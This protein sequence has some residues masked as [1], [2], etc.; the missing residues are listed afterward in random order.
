MMTQILYNLA[1]KP[2]ISANVK[3]RDVNAS[4]WY[5]TAVAWAAAKGLI[6]GCNEGWLIP[7]GTATRAE[8][9]A[10]LMRYCS[11]IGMSTNKS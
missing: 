2:A 7:Q 3:F 10:M 9:A 11:L 5:A 8:V 6:N 1:G 4:D